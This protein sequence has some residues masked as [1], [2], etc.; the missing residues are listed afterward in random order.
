MSYFIRKNFIGAQALKIKA[1]NCSERALQPSR[2]LPVQ[3]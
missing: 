1:L 2:H 3:S